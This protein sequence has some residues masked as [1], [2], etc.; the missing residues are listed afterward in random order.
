MK[1]FPNLVFESSSFDTLYF[2]NTAVRG[3]S[4]QFYLDLLKKTLVTASQ[5]VVNELIGDE[6]YEDFLYNNEHHPDI[7]K[8]YKTIDEFKP[9][10]DNSTMH[11]V[12]CCAISN[13]SNSIQIFSDPHDWDVCVIGCKEKDNHLVKD[14]L[15]ESGNYERRMKSIDEFYAIWHD[16]AIPKMFDYAMLNLKENYMQYIR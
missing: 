1:V 16:I 8:K 7:V 3:Y 14:W 11:H 10:I 4:Q 15:V 2:Y 6:R 9:W 12:P 13:N 5:I